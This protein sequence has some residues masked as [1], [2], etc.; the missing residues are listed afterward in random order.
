[1][2]LERLLK[3]QRWSLR[4]PPEE[5]LEL[6]T[7]GQTSAGERISPK[8]ALSLAAYYDAIRIISEDTAKLPLPVLK[9]LKPRGRERQLNHR[10]DFLLNVEAS[11]VMSAQPFRETITHHALGWGGGYAEIQ[12]DGS[13]P[14]A[15]WL[16]DPELVELK[17]NEGTRELYYE[18]RAAESGEERRLPTS[19]VFHIHGIGYNGLQGYSVARMARE[20]LGEI[21]AAGKAGGAFWGNNSRPG[22]VIEATAPIKDPKKLRE[23][24]E[25]GYKGASRVN[26]TAVLGYG[27]SYKP[28]EIPHQ[29]AQWIEARQFGV[30]EVARWFRIPPHKL[31]HL[32]RA[33]FSNI[34]EQS[35][36]YVTDCLGAWLTRI[37]QEVNRKLLIGT[38]R[39][40]YVEHNVSALLKGNPKA[41]N[42]SYAIGRQWG[43]WSANDVLDK[44][45]E[46]PLP[47]KQGDIYLVPSTHVNA[48]TMIEPP[49]PEPVA[50]PVVPPD[51]ADEGATRMA[52]AERTREVAAASRGIVDR[53]L[54]GRIVDAH[55]PLFADT[56]KRLLRFE[57][58]RLR[59]KED[60][61]YSRYAEHAAEM[62]TRCVAVCVASIGSLVPGGLDVEVAD[63]ASTLAERHVEQSR[64]ALIKTSGA[65]RESVLQKWSNGRAAEQVAELRSGLADY[66]VALVGAR[67]GSVVV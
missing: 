50:L 40:L 57:V 58:D 35:I 62:L 65:S 33:T 20:T 34:V 7:G 31:Q 21:K 39:E 36:E 32:L 15:L 26:K 4:N 43:W 10:V 45:N 41:R 66:I 6:L 1:V 48:E 8:S 24:Y 28:I 29:D 42:E 27:L 54:I 53:G 46:N 5:V 19:K 14:S 51:D 17:Q 9:R 63:Y 37:E 49:K 13:L 3:Q 67:G 30:E 52:I 16:L 12:W 2:F 11:P 56:Y 25:E 23:A 22:G 18:V 64:A 38:R 59:R 44:E 60:L 61:D 55:E 47:G